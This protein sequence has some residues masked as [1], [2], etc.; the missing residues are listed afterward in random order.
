MARA[1]ACL[2]EPSAW[3][4][5]D[6]GVFV[7]SHVGDFYR[8]QL[9]DRTP[10]P[11]LNALKALLDEGVIRPETCRIIL[12]G[13]LSP[14]TVRRIAELGLDSLLETVGVVSHF[15]SVRLMLI[16]DLLLLFDPPGDGTTYV[17]SKL[18]EYLG[19][20]KPIL[21]IVPEG[22]SRELLE[23]S[24]HGLLAS[25]DDPDSIKLIIKKAIEHRD[26][27]T[28]R[29]SFDP[30]SYDRE[31]LTGELSSLLDNLLDGTQ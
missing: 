28:M 9:G 5:T 27:L 19:S 7:I 12:A 13:K 26:M 1:A 10:H 11:L 17:R 24:G 31:R 6:E 4:D 18:Y 22:A 2:D 30:L 3:Q 20:G 21:G 15:D 14:A 8:F 29:T 25:P 23:S 16:S